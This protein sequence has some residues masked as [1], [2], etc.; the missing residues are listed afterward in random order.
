MKYFILSITVF[1]FSLPCI[2]QDKV[3]YTARKNELNFGYFN[4]FELNGTNDFGLGYK[5]LMRNGSIR[6]S[7]GFNFSQHDSETETEQWKTS[8]FGVSPRLG[9]EFHQ[10]FN[11]IRL[12]YGSDVVSSFIKSTSELIADNPNLNRTD[13]SKG[14]ILGVRPIIGLTVFL[15]RS[16]SISTETYLDIHYYKDTEERIRSSGTTTSIDKGMNMGLGPLG[17][18]SINFHF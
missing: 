13:K 14:Y 8:G 17:I 15:N 1:L 9:Y 5:R 3:D 10:S 12:H 6:T 11:R 7:V 4:A 18:V 16:F 2:S